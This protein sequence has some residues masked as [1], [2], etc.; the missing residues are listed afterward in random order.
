M[1]VDSG[2]AIRNAFF[3]NYFSNYFNSRP[4][5]YYE[6]STYGKPTDDEWKWCQ[7]NDFNNKNSEELDEKP[8]EKPNTEIDP[9]DDKWKWNKLVTTGMYKNY[10]DAFEYVDKHKFEDLYGGWKGDEEFAWELKELIEVDKKYVKILDKIDNHK[11]CEHI[12]ESFKRIYAT[13]NLDLH[14]YVT[15]KYK[16][17]KYFIIKYSLRFQLYDTIK[18][19]IKSYDL[20]NWEFNSKNI[21]ATVDFDIKIYK[22]LMKHKLFNYDSNKLFDRTKYYLSY[23]A[24]DDPFVDDNGE[25]CIHCDFPGQYAAHCKECATDYKFYVKDYWQERKIREIHLKKMIKR[26]INKMNQI[27]MM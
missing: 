5:E 22:M 27:N 12:E 3:K 24:P 7:L 1:S 25:Y 18:Y 13:E 17:N 15:K 8:D 4:A 14:R 2:K 26:K 19:M 21:S 23:Y 9:A 10:F 16:K 20:T 11:Y 6:E